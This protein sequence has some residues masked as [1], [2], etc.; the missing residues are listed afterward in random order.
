VALSCWVVDRAGL[1]SHRCCYQ[2]DSGIGLCPTIP[3]CPFSLDH[4]AGCETP[5]RS[6]K[7]QF[8]SSSGFEWKRAPCV[9]LTSMA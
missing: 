2:K 9:D 7:S 3:G 5:T 6:E 4:S 8:A 1:P